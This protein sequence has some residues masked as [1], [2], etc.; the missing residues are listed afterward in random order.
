MY[1]LIYHY[2]ISFRIRLSQTFMGIYASINFLEVPH[3]S[4]QLLDSLF[5][6][7]EAKDNI[8]IA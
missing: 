7:C 3:R 4:N 8:G 6:I 1:S 2:H 5:R